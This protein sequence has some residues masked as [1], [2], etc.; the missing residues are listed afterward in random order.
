MD[1]PRLP[2]ELDFVMRG[3]FGGVLDVLNGLPRDG[4]LD[5]LEKSTGTDELV[6]LGKVFHVI[7]FE[8]QPAS[9][10]QGQGHFFD[11]AGIEQPALVVAVLG[12]WIREINMVGLDGVRDDQQFDHEVG[13]QAKEAAVRA[14]PAGGAQ[15]G[16]AQPFLGTLDPQEIGVRA[17]ERFSEDEPSLAGADLDFH[18]AG[19]A[20]DRGEIEM[21]VDAPRGDQAP[22]DFGSVLVNGFR[23]HE[24]GFEALLPLLDIA[25]GSGI[26]RKH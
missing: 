8:V 26:H 6:G 19:I 18:G 14:R 13:V 11:E 17:L 21:F 25:S 1:I 22:L 3:G 16:D 5:R 12:P 24:L 20:V 7:G 4:F 2:A 15:Q 9:G 23:A 10:D